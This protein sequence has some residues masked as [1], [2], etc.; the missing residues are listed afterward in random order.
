[1]IFIDEVGFQV[2]IVMPIW[3]SCSCEQPTI[4]GPAIRSRNITLTITA[5]AAA[6][7]LHYKILAKSGN[8]TSC[9]YFID[10]LAAT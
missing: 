6:E 10:D 5:L 2:V 7:M 4:V 9:F 8:Q 1:M 3:S